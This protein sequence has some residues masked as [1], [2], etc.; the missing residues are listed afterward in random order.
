M[1]MVGVGLRPFRVPRQAPAG[2]VRCHAGRARDVVHAGRQAGADAS[3]SGQGP[4]PGTGLGLI[5]AAQVAALHGAHSICQNPGPKK[6]LSK[7]L[8]ARPPDLM[9]SGDLAAAGTAFIFASG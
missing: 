5:L 8:L 6:G 7:L 4:L 1:P 9:S 2:F 3:R